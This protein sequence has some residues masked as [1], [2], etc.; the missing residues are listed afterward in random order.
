[1]TAQKQKGGRV[2][3]RLS[4]IE[5][6]TRS[7]LGR[8]EAEL[9]PAAL[10]VGL[11]FPAALLVRRLEGT[12]PTDFLQ[13]S[14]G[15]QLVFQALQGPVH[16]FTFTNYHF[17][18]VSSSFLKMSGFEPAQPSLRGRLAGVNYCE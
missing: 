6:R 2:S 10:G 9:R 16:R 14:F 5:S 1:M 8:I 11:G 4:K 13:N 15:I 17:R 3:D 18:H 12:E 7:R